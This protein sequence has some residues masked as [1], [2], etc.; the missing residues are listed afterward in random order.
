MT[1]IRNIADLR[2]ALD[3]RHAIKN[4]ADLR[5][6]IDHFD[7][8]PQAQRHAWQAYIIVRAHDLDATELLPAAWRDSGPTTFDPWVSDGTD[9]DGSDQDVTNCP[10]CGAELDDDDQCPNC[11][12]N[13]DR[14]PDGPNKLDGSASQGNVHAVG[15]PDGTGSV[16]SKQP[17]AVRAGTDAAGNLV[18]TGQAIVYNLPTT[19]HDRYGSFT[20]VIAPGAARSSALALG[21]NVALLHGHDGKSNPPLART[22][23]GTLRLWDSPTG[24]K[25]RAVLDPGSPAAQSVTSAVRR[26]DLTGM[27]FSFRCEPSGERW[28]SSMSKRVITEFSE[29]PEISCVWNP[30][31]TVGTSAAVEEAAHARRRAAL[32]RRVELLRT[33]LDLEKRTNV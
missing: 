25:Y 32:H 5:H 22:T 11:T 10:A 27:S 16:S 14:D 18:L 3:L 1:T 6:A 29:V 7:E 33:R 12:D 26:G 21:A 15:V 8:V 24:V 30:A 23:S 28:D 4:I 9:S 20:E 19:I 13:Q 2:H 17:F 31:Y